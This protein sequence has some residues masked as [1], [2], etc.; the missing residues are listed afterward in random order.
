MLG[1]AIADGRHALAQ[2]S[3]ESSA[4]GN[5]AAMPTGRNSPHVGAIGGTLYVAGGQLSSNYG[6]TVLEAY[7]PLTDTWITKTPMP[8]R[9]YGGTV[10]VIDGKLYVAGGWNPPDSYVP[11]NTLQIYDPVGNSWSYG[12]SIPYLSACGAAG[13]IAGKL[14]LLTACDGY[15]AYK[16][17]FAVFDPADGGRWSALP[18]PANI[19]AGPA[20][21]VI[22]GKFYVAGGFNGSVHTAVLEVY[23]PVG[24]T[25]T[26]KT[27]MPTARTSPFGGT[28]DGKLFVAGGYDRGVELD[29]VE[30]YD[31]GD[32]SWTTMAS[33]PTA[34]QGGHNGISS[35][36]IDGKLYMVGGTTAG[37]PAMATLEVFSPTVD[38]PPVAD[39][40]PDQAVRA[41]DSVVLD[42]S[43]SFDD[44][45]ATADLIYAWAFTSIPAGSAAVLAGDTTQSP[46]FVA[47]LTGTYVAQLIVTD[48]AGLSSDTDEVLISSEN[49]APTAL[50]GDD[51]LV[52]TGDLVILDGS[53]S[54]DP[55]GDLIIFSWT[56]TT[57]PAASS[58]GLTGDDTETPTLTPDVEGLYGIELVVS[59]FIGPSTPDT[60]V[61][62]ATD[63]VS[64]AE[65]Q[66]Q[67]ANNI[68][69]ALPPY[70]V[71]TKGNQQALTNFLI[72]AT[73][74]LQKGDLVKALDKLEKLI[75]RTDGCTLRGTPDGDGPGRDW[76]TDCTA[77][78][79]V[80]QQLNDALIALAS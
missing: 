50:A 36:E 33:M 38:L 1:F 53:G 28:L 10:G 37:F 44:N 8:G 56:L 61:I 41:G 67:S 65:I 63:T 24:N 64:F 69:M 73:T 19:H 22:D 7:D 40:G 9:R 26:T 59:D 49:L 5:V 45:T 27:A 71:T 21:G 68:V 47:D 42:G 12:P 2:G 16:K 34:R 51:V 62:T 35:P 60:V 74:A 4:Y 14:Y 57:Q 66:I 17:F 29:T 80:Y 48:K 76:I 72:Q 30:A 78:Q 79:D 43:A 11:T 55:E 13:V 54:T 31:P 32:D 23:D 77:Q 25:W 46:T 15:S 6:T 3:W 18:E 75:E 58:A 70:S 39:A 52:V 20:S